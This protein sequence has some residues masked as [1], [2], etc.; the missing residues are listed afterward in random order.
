MIYHNRLK[1]IMFFIIIVIFVISCSNN[2][3]QES[4]YKK[5][6]SKIIQLEEQNQLLSDAIKYNREYVI[7]LEA[8]YTFNISENTR[9]IFELEKLLNKK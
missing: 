8:Q 5:L 6:E 3:I 4:K 1:R 2:T 7:E 9:K